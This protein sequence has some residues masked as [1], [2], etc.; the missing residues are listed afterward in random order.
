MVLCDT[1]IL[2]NYFNGNVETSE[3][4]EQIGFE[5]VLLSSVTVME[6]IQ[7]MT[8]KL[9]LN[10]MK[11][12][13]KYYDVLHFDQEISEKAIL[14]IENYKLSHNLQ[15]PDAIIGATA[16]IHNVPLFTYN[17]KDFHFMPNLSL[18]QV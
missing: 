2:I 6:L 16:L 15:I 17:L 4:L 3:K 8:T 10:Q 14:L 5:N 7:G 13:L 9:E 18:V 12:I 11:K 1:N